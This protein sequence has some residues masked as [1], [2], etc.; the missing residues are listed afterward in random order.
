MICIAKSNSYGFDYDSY[1]D[2]VVPYMLIDGS[3]KFP[4]IIDLGKY[5]ILGLSLEITETQ[6]YLV[7]SAYI[8]GS[9]QKFKIALQP[10]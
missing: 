1:G 2:S 10:Y 6:W 5:P 8:T 9:P 4:E 7:V 3:S